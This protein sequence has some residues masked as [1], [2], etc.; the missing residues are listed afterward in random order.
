[1]AAIF[2]AAGLSSDRYRL[3]PPSRLFLLPR[4]R[5]RSRTVIIADAA[6]RSLFF[7]GNFDLR[8]RRRPTI[9]R[10][11]RAVGAIT[12]RRVRGKCLLNTALDARANSIVA[13]YDYDSSVY[14]H[15]IRLVNELSRASD[16]VW[17]VMLL[18]T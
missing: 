16:L 5:L 15:L 12:I 9:R 11:G 1:M 3:L 18:I 7:R 14:N 6:F 13:H 4:R 2:K 17:V 10:R 8:R